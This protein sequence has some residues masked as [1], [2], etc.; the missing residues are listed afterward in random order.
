MTFFDVFSA[1]TSSMPAHTPRA[2]RTSTDPALKPRNWAPWFLSALMAA[3]AP[4]LLAF[5]VAP[6]STFLNQALSFGCWGWFVM[7][8]AWGQH[9]GAIDW[10]RVSPL[11]AALVSV[12][13]A[14]AASWLLG[15]L[16]ASLALSA[17]ATLF[18]ALLVAVA[19][20]AAARGPQALPFFAAFCWG[21]VAAGALGVAIGVVQVFLPE[22]TDGDWIAHPGIVGRAVGNLR[23]PNH[24]SSVL[25]WACVALVALLELRRLRLPTAAALFTLM[26]FAVVLTASRTG[27]LSV[28]LLALW[29]VVDR[30]LL[31]ATR[32][33]L[34][35]APLV[36]LLAW[37]AMSAWGQMGEHNFGGAARLA[38]TDISG[39]RFGIWANALSL[40]AQQ[41]WRGVGFGEFN[42]AWSLTPFPGRPV[43]FFD[44]AHNLPLHLAAELGLPLAAIVLT[45]LLWALWRITHAALRADG[46]SGATL[47]CAVVMVVMIGL[48]SLLE[49]PLWYAYFLLPAAWV[50]GYAL[51]LPQGS[52]QVS[53]RMPATARAGAVSLALLF[54]GAALVVGA[55]LS[56]F[57][58]TRVSAIFSATEGAAPLQQRIAAGQ[59][60]VFFAHHADYAAA[61]VE[62]QGEGESD[63]KSLAP[64]R[65]ATHFLLDTR[66]MMAW[67]EALRA[68][69]QDDA[70]RHV[71]MR[72]REFRNPL[73]Q[74]FFAV[75]GAASAAASTASVAAP[76]S[77]P[78]QCVPSAPTKVDWRELTR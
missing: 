60:S 69:G 59:R 36:F 11:A 6:S 63:G 37:L 4:T 74:E 9:N 62:G 57:D 18:A 78:F 44:H 73:S 67:A 61:T 23:Q 41:P 40:I 1:P 30:R 64:F 45:L 14:A 68:S 42:F 47:R 50:W 8:C 10:R 38:E 24:L 13:G 70:A 17:V 75:C 58:Y 46:D 15:S 32:G 12:I 54:A 43:A 35:A 31:R 48:H 76:A 77:V 52:P 19:G 65:G 26:V 20:G 27:L 7:A 2:V 49:Y 21:W 33:M 3:A 72:L 53:H 39:S 22:L 5:N 66:L 51:G 34:I 71:V 56:V 29:G 16:P 55:A 25:L 28:L